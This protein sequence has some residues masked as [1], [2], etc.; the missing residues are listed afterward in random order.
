MIIGV[1][2]KS[3]ILRMKELKLYG[4]DDLRD[5]CIYLFTRPY[6]SDKI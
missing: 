6:R 5:R 1:L 4:C 2:G 3:L